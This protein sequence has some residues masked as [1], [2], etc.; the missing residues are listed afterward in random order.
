MIL[1]KQQNLISIDTTIGI[2]AALLNL[3]F[4]EIIYIFKIKF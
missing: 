2:K 3:K 4:Y 1:I